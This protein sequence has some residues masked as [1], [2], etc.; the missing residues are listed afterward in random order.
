VT[1]PR[2]PGGALDPAH[3]PHQHI[4]AVIRI[5]IIDGTLT[6]GQAVSITT[7]TQEFA[8][9]RITA[10]KAL[11]QLVS[12]GRMEQPRG[13]DYYVRQPAPAPGG[14]VITN[15]EALAALT[16]WEARLKAVK[17]EVEI[18]DE[19][20]DILLTWQLQATARVEDDIREHGPDAPAPWPGPP[21]TPGSSQADT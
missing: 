9:A 2:R 15:A 16:E 11:R 4:A 20:T 14:H 19:K 7:L 8:V 18:L 5:R 6:P 10:R 13:Y 17:H 3:V 21:R 1:P 12:E